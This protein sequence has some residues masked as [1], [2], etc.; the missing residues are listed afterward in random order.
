MITVC[1]CWVCG[2]K[3]ERLRRRGDMQE[4]SRCINKQRCSRWQKDNAERVKA[5]KVQSCAEVKN[6][7]AK[8]EK[9][10]AKARV[11]AQR[12]R[13]RNPDKVVQQ[14]RARYLKN[15]DAHIQKVVDR[16]KRLRDATPPWADLEAIAKIYAQARRLTRE[17]GVAHQVDHFFPLKGK[18]SCGLHVEYNLRIVSAREN[19]SKHNKLPEAA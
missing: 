11:K 12:W 4:C 2:A 7:Y 3:F 15:P 6:R 17:T 1:R 16:S 19:Q 9:G 5:T 10:R 18:T 13:Q 8:S 14:A